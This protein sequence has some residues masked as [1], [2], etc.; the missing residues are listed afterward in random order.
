[1]EKQDFALVKAIKY[2]RVYILYS[3]VIAYVPNA[4]VKDIITQD[5]L[6]G[7]SGKWIATILEY[8][9]ESTKLIKG[10]CLAKLMAESN[11]QALDINFITEMD[12]GEEMETP[13]I[14]Q[15]FI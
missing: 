4:V 7:K 13:Q 10:Q 3:H 8:D 9:L 12:N 15:D 1:M 14:N 5:G 6:D 2:F 11:C